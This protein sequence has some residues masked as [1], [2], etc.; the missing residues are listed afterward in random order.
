MPAMPVQIHWLD[1]RENILIITYRAGVTWNDFTAVVAGLPTL[2]GVGKKP[3]CVI[4]HVRHL[5]VGPL[6][7]RLLD[8]QR[9]TPAGVVASFVVPATHSISDTIITI[10]MALVARH[11]PD[12]V[13][14]EQ[15]ATLEHA[16]Q[17]CRRLLAQA[18]K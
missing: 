11:L 6:L 14:F 1:E 15:A 12:S 8:M 18:Q 17:Q 4:H 13:I 16:V 2:Y 7:S 9:N 10:M 5:P 3:V